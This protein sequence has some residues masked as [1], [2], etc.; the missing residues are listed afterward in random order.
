MRLVDPLLQRGVKVYDISFWRGTSEEPLRRL[1]REVHYPPVID[2][3]DPYILL[4]HQ[5]MVESLFIDDMKK[6]GVEV[7][8]NC[9]FESYSTCDSLVSKKV[10]AALQINTR[11]N[12]T[13][14]KRTI[15]AQY[16][17]GCEFSQPNFLQYGFIDSFKAMARTPKCAR[18]SQKPDQSACHS[19]WSGVCWM[20]KLRP[21]FQIFGPRRSSSHK[22]MAQY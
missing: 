1:G 18:V 20:A 8:R 21:T 6:R 11:V 13:Q 5:G 3:L 19:Q 14:D 17:V 9:A 12:V 22:S 7:K 2:V 16:L 4:V 10:G 15:L